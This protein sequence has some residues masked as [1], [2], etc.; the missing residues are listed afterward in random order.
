MQLSICRS[1]DASVSFNLYDD[2][3]AFAHCRLKKRPAVYSQTTQSRLSGIFLDF[4]WREAIRHYSFEQQNGRSNPPPWSDAAT[5]TLLR[6]SIGRLMTG[7][8]LPPH[9]R[10]AAIEFAETKAV[11]NEFGAAFFPLIQQT[12]VSVKGARLIPEYKFPSAWRSVAANWYEIVADT[13]II[14]QKQLDNPNPES[15]ELRSVICAALPRKLPRQFEIV[16]IYKGQR[17]PLSENA[18]AGDLHSDWNI[19]QWCIHSLAHLRH[20]QAQTPPVIAGMVIYLNELCPT[21]DALATFADEMEQRSTDI[22]PPKSSLME[23]GLRG[24]NKIPTV[25]RYRA[26]RPQLPFAFRLNRAI[27]LFKITPQTIKKALK[28]VDNIVIRLAIYRS[29]SMN[30][31]AWADNPDKT[32]VIPRQSWEWE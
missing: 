25:L 10:P 3:A 28:T 4:A 2:L 22:V 19:D 29:R 7:R 24:W 23:K 6:R 17:R 13:D 16:I 8:I 31:V 21:F 30:P 9:S 27:R 15:E 5:K 26:N 32:G 14:T 18:A 12:G 11:I 20:H 1:G